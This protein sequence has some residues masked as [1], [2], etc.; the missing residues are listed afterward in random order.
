MY[1]ENTLS[2]YDSQGQQVVRRANFLLLILPKTHQRMHEPIKAIVQKV[3][4]S[5]C[6]HWMMGKARIY[7]HSI[8]VS[9][10]YG[11]DGLICDVPDEVYDRASVVLPG[12]LYDAWNKGGGHNSCGSEAP[13]MRRWANENLV[14]LKK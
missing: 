2:G 13:A 8:T 5:Q 11:G 7:G 4:L 9:G 10:S 3:A 14:Q 6:G 12:A 1:I